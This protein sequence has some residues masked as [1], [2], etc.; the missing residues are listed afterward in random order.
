VNT[1]PP[2]PP[3]EATATAKRIVDE[4]RRA[5]LGPAAEMIKAATLNGHPPEKIAL[6][7]R[8]MIQS[9]EWAAEFLRGRLRDH[10]EKHARRIIA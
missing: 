5:V 3:D 7:Y 10:E 1:T 4:T 2:P 6:L 8:L 9:H